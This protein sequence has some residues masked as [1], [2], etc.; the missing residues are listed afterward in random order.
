MIQRYLANPYLIDGLKFDFRLYVL[1]TSCSPLRV[2]LYNDGLAR[3]STEPDQEPEATNSGDIFMHLTNYSINKNNDKFVQSSHIDG[4]GHKRS[5]R[6]VLRYLNNNR[7]NTKLLWKRIKRLVIKT[8][9][10]GQPML[11]SYY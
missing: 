7:V 1:I 5:V 2:F 3:F 4:T 9:C 10:A 11:E 6:S 8:L